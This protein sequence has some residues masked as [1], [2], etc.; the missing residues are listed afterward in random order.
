MGTNSRLFGTD[1]I[2]G[3]VGKDPITPQFSYRLG[4]ALTKVFKKSASQFACIGM[5][6]RSSGPELANAMECGLSA[7]GVGSVR[8]GV[9]PTPG[10][11]YTTRHTDADFGI[12]LTASHNPANCNGFK[13]FNENGEKLSLELEDEIERASRD[14]TD[15][16]DQ[17]FE[18]FAGYPDSWQ[19]SVYS[20]YLKSLAKQV[21]K[22]SLTGV[23]DCANG[24]TTTI[25]P[26][27]MTDLLHEVCFIGNQPDGN[28]INEDCGSTQPALLAK[29]VTDLRADI[30]IAFDGDGD[31]ILVVDETGRILS[32]DHILYMLLE[33]ARSNNQYTGGVVSTQVSNFGLETILKSKRVPFVRTDVGDRHV[34][35]ALED[36]D[37]LIGGE[38][39]G[40]IIHRSYSHTG[41]GLLIAICL[42]DA[43]SRSEKRLRERLE[44]L[45]LLPQVQFSV[46]VTNPK[47]CMNHKELTKSIRKIE[48]VVAESGRVVVRA[49]GTESVVRVMVEHEKADVAHEIADELVHVV[50]SCDYVQK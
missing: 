17:K 3:L 42:L 18:Q 16:E 39:S 1:G 19:E 50:Q 45:K 30:G 22:T 44:P 4:I 24:A 25:A 5:D 14:T 9:M 20:Q 34:T 15:D 31:R 37:W 23:I 7:G 2:R 48:S 36:K 26:L 43:L 47:V 41:D 21:G 10:I 33:D 46:P 13:V 12:A 29:T 8:L 27:V 6:S 28:N 35:D 49:S 40:H 32:G 11:A 38:P